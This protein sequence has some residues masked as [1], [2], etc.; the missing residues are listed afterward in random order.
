MGRKKKKN[1]K[2]DALEEIEGGRLGL[3]DE[4]LQAVIAVI[5]LAG[6]IFL[7]LAALHTAGV[8]GERIHSTL[9]TLLGIGYF[10][11]PVLCL[12]L[13]V[14]FFKSIRRK[15]PKLQLIGSGLFFLTSLGL[16][17]VIVAGEGGILGGLVAHPLISLFD[18]VAAFILTFALFIISILI[19]FNA[20]LQLENLMF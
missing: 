18:S 2:K 8:A 11:L 13:A 3:R 4:T 16:I 5:F 15:I 10:L 17:E 9:S 7:T 1:S 12:I 19:L 6:G 20:T 14:F